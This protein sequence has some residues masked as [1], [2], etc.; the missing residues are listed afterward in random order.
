MVRAAPAA[1]SGSGGTSSASL[2]VAG[3]ILVTAGN[4]V[5]TGSGT[6]AG[7]TP[8]AAGLQLVS[9]TVTRVLDGT[10]T[11]L[12]DLGNGQSAVARVAGATVGSVI[13]VATPAGSL[14]PTNGQTG[15]VGVALLTPDPAK[16]TVAALSVLPTVNGAQLASALTGGS[17]LTGAI[18]ATTGALDLTGQTSLVQANLAN[19]SVGGGNP[20]LAV[21]ALSPATTTGTL[22][23]ATL[24]PT[25]GGG[26]VGA[27]T[28][29]AAG[30]ATPAVATVQSATGGVTGVTGAVTPVI[31]AVTPVVAAITPG[32]TAPVTIAPTVSATVAPVVAATGA[33]PGAVAPGVTATVVPVV[34]ALVR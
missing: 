5:L 16:G 23:T 33:V 13:N 1:T 12:I 30:I 24:L 17:S 3:P 11:A 10:G 25:A 22:A 2:G 4:A 34:G 8:D 9:G 28:G 19:L 15:A 21:N 6:I 27:V 26:A 29:T 32:V 7:A 18:A 31:A 20:A 14:L